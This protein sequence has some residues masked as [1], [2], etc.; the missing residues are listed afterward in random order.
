MHKRIA[1]KSSIKI[2]IKIAPTCFGVITI[3]RERTIR[4][5][6]SYS[7]ENS[8]LKYIGVVNLVVW[9]HMLSGLLCS[10]LSEVMALSKVDFIVVQDDWNYILPDTIY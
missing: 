4:S 8:Q 5:W 9:L 2:Y 3:I 10:L 1:F 7:R 6:Y